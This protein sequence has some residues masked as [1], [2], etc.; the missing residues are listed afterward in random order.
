M[1]DDLYS[2]EYVANR[3]KYK[4]EKITYHYFKKQLLAWLSSSAE[5][6][7][8]EIVKTNKLTDFWS[9]S[10]IP[11]ADL[12]N[13]GGVT[14]ARGKK[15]EQL[16][17]RI[18]DMSTQ[19]GDFVLDFH[20]GS[21]TTVAVS[22]KMGRKYI[23]IEQLNYGDNDVIKRLNNV[24]KGDSTG[25][26]KSVEWKGG[27][28]FT[29]IELKKWNQEYFDEIEEVSTSKKLL[30][31]YEK[32]KNEAF[33]RYEVDLSRFDTKEFSKLELADQKRVLLDCLDKNH[34]YVNFNDIND[35]T[36][37]VSPEDKKLNKLFYEA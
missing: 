15:P 21:G 23:G 16:L 10:D 27:G 29:Y 30:A 12:A 13:E 25:I 36:Y 31:V 6:N 3:G 2:V 20:T 8:T 35:S 22:H 24:I 4:G 19:P 11:K 26:S 28:S 9:H 32:M 37:K 34:L 1:N 5:S 17:K 14:L 18:I 7:G 33:F